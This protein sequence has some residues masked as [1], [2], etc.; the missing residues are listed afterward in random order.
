MFPADDA[1]NNAWNLSRSVFL[2]WLGVGVGGSLFGTFIYGFTNKYNY[3][4]KRFALQFDTLP[5]GFKGLKIVQISDI[6][7]GS[8]TNKEAVQKGVDMILDE[9]PDLILFT[10]DLVN[11]HASEMND[12]M[13]VFSRIQAP[14]GVFSTLG[15]H[16]YGDYVQWASPAAKKENLENVKN[17]HA[18]LGW[19]LLMNEHV[20]LTAKRR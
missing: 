6:H 17:I 8:F 2:S 19:R 10:G 16:D 15:N 14:M 5:A 18:Q 3:R 9:K 20:P 7:S 13:D 12:Y 4:I 11:D 1:D